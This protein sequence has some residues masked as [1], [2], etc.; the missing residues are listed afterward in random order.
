MDEALRVFIQIDVTDLRKILLYFLSECNMEHYKRLRHIVQCDDRPAFVEYVTSM[1]ADAIV[2]TLMYLTKSKN[3]H[4]TAVEKRLEKIKKETGSS[5]QWNYMKT[6]PEAYQ[7]SLERHRE[8]LRE[9]RK[10]DKS[11]SVSDLKK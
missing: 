1:N 4:D 5:A 3:T 8:Y 11:A 2:D 6:H 10:R 7:K 9:K